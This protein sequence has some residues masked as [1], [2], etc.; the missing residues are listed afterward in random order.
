MKALWHVGSAARPSRSSGGAGSG[1]ICAVGSVE[2]G[3]APLATPE[4][5]HGDVETGKQAAKDLSAELLA[6]ELAAAT[7]RRTVTQLLALYE[8]TCRRTRRARNRP[9]ISG[10][11]RSG[12]RCSA[13]G[14]PTRSTNDDL[15]AFVRDRRAGRITVEEHALRGSVT[16]TTVGADII[17]LNSVLNWATRKKLLAVN[18]VRG[19]KRPKSANPRQPVATYDRFEKIMTVADRVDPFFGVFLA[20]VEALGWRV[21]AICQLQADD[22][23]RRKL[24]NTP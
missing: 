12:R 9:R 11:P 1:S 7:G 15:D 4:P 22:V 14:R 18:P 24:P 8:R 19:F 6:G 21:S 13:T 5:Q 23:D 16:D 3:H 20:L 17:F 10:E 2:V